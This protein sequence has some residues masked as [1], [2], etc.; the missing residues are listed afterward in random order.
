[1]ATATAPAEE[2]LTAVESVHRPPKAPWWRGK[3]LPT[4]TALVIL[5]L[6]TPILVMIL[7]SFNQ[8]HARL[9][10]VSFKWQGFTLQW[11]REWNGIPGLLSAFGKTL[12]I[13]VTASVTAA[14]I[15][16][17]LALALVRYRFHGK[18][19]QEQVMFMNIAAP[20]IVMG[21]SL[22]GFFVT[23]GVNR[24]FTTLFLA[25]VTFCIAYVAIT[26]RARLAGF[27]RSLEEAA[28]DL[29]ADAWTTFVKVTLPLIWPGVLAG[30]MMAFALSIDDFVISNFVFGNYETFPL[31][32]YGAVR[33]GI[34]PQVFVFGT[35]I[36]MVGLTIAL[37]SLV[38][39]RRKK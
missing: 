27:D 9:P 7:Y 21:A 15:G 34:P 3:I 26:V 30:F 6:V 36:F 17:L 35:V 4:Y 2:S 18:A 13:A 31:W 10:Q 19:V 5:Y 22:L 24:G 12:T 25:H 29:G 32:V 1:V 38:L 20:E 11:Y 16:T 37:S 14:I 28:A 33:V 39:A 23:I 8:S